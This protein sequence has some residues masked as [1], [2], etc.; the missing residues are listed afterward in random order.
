MTDEINGEDKGNKSEREI[1]KIDKEFLSKAKNSR[2]I[3]DKTLR[4]VEST[5]EN[6]SETFTNGEEE[7]KAEELKQSEKEEGISE[8][9]KETRIILDRILKKIEEREEYLAALQE[10]ISQLDERYNRKTN[11]TKSLEERFTITKESKDNLDDEYKELLRNNEQLI[12]TYESRQVDLIVL[13]DS[14]KEKIALQDELRNK[15]A[16]LNQDFRENEVSLEKQR[17]ES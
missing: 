3:I 6:L 13:T 7:E 5:I 16:K 4:N 8:K 1:E 14:V 11:E 17:E 10:T 15:I 12:R 9:L 2:D